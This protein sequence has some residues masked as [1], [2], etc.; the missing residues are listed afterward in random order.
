MVH[1]SQL[2][3]LRPA[4]VFQ[5]GSHSDDN[6][7]SEHFGRG[8]RVHMNDVSDSLPCYFSRSVTKT[9]GKNSEV[10]TVDAWERA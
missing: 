8:V 7:E 9:R 2:V 4:Q 5:F 3:P 10:C 1:G 6:R